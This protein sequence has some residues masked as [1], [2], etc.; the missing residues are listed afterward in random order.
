[1]IRWSGRSGNFQIIF[2]TLWYN[3]NGDAN[4]FIMFEVGGENGDDPAFA[5]IFEDGSLG[6][7]LRITPGANLVPGWGPTGYIRNAA[8]ANDGVSTG[9]QQIHGLAFAITDLLDANGVNLTND[10]VIKG[11]MLVDRGGTDPSPHRQNWP[12]SGRSTRQTRL[13]VQ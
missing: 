6:A 10:A 13:K 3:T 5:A 2:D 4:D 1:M 12:I 7:T 11:V 9:N 8:D